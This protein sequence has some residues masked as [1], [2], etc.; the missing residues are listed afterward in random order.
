MRTPQYSQLSRNASLL[1][2]LILVVI[3]ATFIIAGPG[4]LIGVSRTERQVDLLWLAYL[5][6]T[7][8]E[9]PEPELVDEIEQRVNELGANSFFRII[10]GRDP[11]VGEW[12][13]EIRVAIVALR[14][15]A[16][17]GTTGA[18]GPTGIT[19]SMRRT[20]TVAF[21]RLS[22]Y[23]QE[24]ASAQRQALQTVI[25]AALILL[26]GIGALLAHLYLQNRHL[27]E[28][29]QEA[30]DAQSR[31]IRETHHRVKNNL[32]LVA[33]LVSI[34]EAASDPPIDLSDLKN[35]IYAVER[36][37]AMLSENESGLLVP[38]D[39]YLSDLVDSVLMSASLPGLR[40]E[41]TVDPVALTAKRAVL[42]GI[43]VN[44]AITNAVKHGFSGPG[45]HELAVSLIAETRSGT[46]TLVV[47]NSSATPARPAPDAPPASDARPAPQAVTG[48]LG[49]QLLQGVVD[50]L[51][52]TMELTWE[53]RPRLQV[54][55]PLD[56][57]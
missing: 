42:V 23:V 55:F 56:G 33:S 57:A 18:S 15:Y 44:E 52:G 7:Q 28:S 46:A 54:V 4:L 8:E 11:V 10:E 30:L 45:P 37:H 50:Q 16:D 36:V 1:S 47:S 35:R 25:W 41:L 9:V 32:A 48:S 2:L 29:L 39:H 40:K 43:I 19:E 38:L 20:V 21:E 49:F 24:H 5:R 17:A 12:L 34:R 13:T 31:L 51:G 26:L 14:E 22:A 3:V 53:P 27:S 6:A